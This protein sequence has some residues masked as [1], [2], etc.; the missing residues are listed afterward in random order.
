MTEVKNRLK[1][2]TIMKL[3]T[4]ATIV[5]VVL[6]I[7]GAVNSLQKYH[8]MTASVNSLTRLRDTIRDFLLL[9]SDQSSNAQLFA[10][11]LDSRYRD[12]WMAVNEKG[13]HKKIVRDISAV[14]LNEAEKKALAEVE[15]L[16]KTTAETQD[17]AL[18]VDETLGLN[19]SDATM[20][21]GRVSNREAYDELSRSTAEILGSDEN[22]YER[23]RLVDVF[24]SL[25]ESIL[26]RVL[27]D[28]EHSQSTMQKWLFFEGVILALLLVMVLIVH[29]VLNHRVIRPMQL[30]ERHF[31]R[32]TGGDLHTNITL[33]ADNTETGQLVASANKM[34]DMFSRYIRE[35]ETVLYELSQGNLNQKVSDDFIG[36]FVKIRESL[37]QILTSYKASFAEINNAAFEVSNGSEQIA[38]SSQS[39]SEGATE[40]A[41]T[42]E[43]LTANVNEVTVRISET[44]ENAEGVKKAAVEMTKVI[45]TGAQSLSRLVQAMKELTKY[46]ADIAKII[47]TIDNI[48]FQTNILAL[49]AS[50]EAARAEQNGASFSVVADE[51]R[52]L[53]AQ[54]AKSAQATTQLIEDTLSTI[55]EGGEIAASTEEVLSVIVE[56]SENVQL[57]V[58]KITEAMESDSIAVQQALNSLEQLSSIV[59][60]NSA[61]AEE[62]AAASEEI[63]AQAAA[64]MALVK[65]FS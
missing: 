1:A 28:V 16:L 25:Q 22:Q 64:M 55:K 29:Y 14:G 38:M 4:V 6:G 30:L 13:L 11:T 61:N 45:K 8:Q 18:H 62:T 31:A 43:E 34:Q 58:T 33:E 7:F 56:R 48:A 47:K 41:S 26:K 46:S 32:I 65:K 60:A 54:S 51:V 17:N 37:M 49:N 24:N 27:Q 3:C 53:A 2:S 42:I 21:A 5:L 52:G 63:S 35:V 10:L 44:V 12:K 40:Q 39:L 15:R 57:L 20:V 59:Q 19:L 9:N 36:D 50:V 23:R